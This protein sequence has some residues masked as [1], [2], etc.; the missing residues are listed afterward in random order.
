MAGRPAKQGL[1]ISLT[2]WFRG[3][4][5]NIDC[6]GTKH[7]RACS[8]KK[9][10]A[11]CYDP[12]GITLL[13]QTRCALAG[14]R[15]RGGAR[16]PHRQGGW[17]STSLNTARSGAK[18]WPGW[19]RATDIFIGHLHSNVPQKAG[20]YPNLPHP[21]RTLGHIIFCQWFMVC[22]FHPGS[23]EHCFASNCPIKHLH[24]QLAGGCCKTSHM[25]LACEHRSIFDVV[26]CRQG[27]DIG[28][29]QL[30]GNG[31]PNTKFQIAAFFV[32]V[33]PTQRP[34]IE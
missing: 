12:L 8:V 28:F 10:T 2:V 3:W 13:E 34:R 31:E 9:P 1:L 23:E 26:Y 18:A 4:E 17:I 21:F 14:R 24:W 33:S 30:P 29:K 27:N 25:A 20:A 22:V 19:T 6:T 16:Y 32:F 15:A 5:C 7:S 11:P